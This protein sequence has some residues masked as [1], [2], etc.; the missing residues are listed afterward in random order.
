MWI[1]SNLGVR[2]RKDALVPGVFGASDGVRFVFKFEIPD[3]LGF[4]RIFG[5]D[6]G[7]PVDCSV[8][9]IK[10]RRASDIWRNY[11]VVLADATHAVDL[12]RQQDGNPAFLEFTC[13]MDHRGAAQAVTIENDSRGV[14]FV[15]GEH[16][17]TICT[18]M[19]KNGPECFLS[20]PIF[21]GL[22]INFAGIFRT[23]LV[24]QFHLATNG[25]IVPDDASHN[26]DDKHR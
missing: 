7:I 22:H 26:P 12:N 25:V 9:L 8:G 24:R 15:L 2:L 14:L 5:A 19:G 11:A 1:A 6:C 4:G 17:F 21:K 18:Q 16:G 20:V 10:I 13:E 3:D 23:Q